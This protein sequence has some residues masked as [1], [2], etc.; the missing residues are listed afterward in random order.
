[1]KFNLWMAGLLFGTTCLAPALSQAGGA[2]AA[3]KADTRADFA[4]LVAALKTQMLPGGRCEF[5]SSSGR[6]T[7]AFGPGV[8]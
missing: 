4:A 2:Q 1:M 7:I 8:T 6:K 3:N 5:V